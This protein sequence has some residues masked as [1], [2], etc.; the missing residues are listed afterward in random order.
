MIAT[1]LS[2]NDFVAKMNN[3]SSLLIGFGRESVTTAEAGQVHALAREG[4]RVA[5][6]RLL[7]GREA[8]EYSK[9]SLANI[10][11][12]YGLQ[13]AFDLAEL[14]GC[15]AVRKNYLSNEGEGMIFLVQGDS[16][17]VRAFLPICYPRK[18]QRG[19]KASIGYLQSDT[20]F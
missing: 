15:W 12:D 3:L 19:V 9:E 8:R 20:P 1:Q 16:I 2:Q 18:T 5:Y 14:D 17:T 6:D 10:I 13:T 4:V 11:E 7:D